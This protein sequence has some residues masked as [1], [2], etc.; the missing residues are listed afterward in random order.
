MA[1]S[2]TAS[3][4]MPRRRAQ[5]LDRGFHLAFG[6]VLTFPKAEAVR[7]AARLTP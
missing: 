3:P 5:A 6:G 7:E 1:A 2:C 4:A